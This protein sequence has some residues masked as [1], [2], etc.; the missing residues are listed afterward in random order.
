MKRFNKIVITLLIL[1]LFTSCVRIET[2]LSV[3]KDGSGTVTEKVMFSKVFVEMMS[4]LGESFGGDSDVSESFSIYDEEKLIGKA[5]DYG[6]GVKYQSSKKISENDWEGYAATYAFT[7]IS[8]VKLNTD[9]NDKIDTGMEEDEMEGESMMDE[10]D[11]YYF[12]SFE[13]GGNPKLII[14]RYEVDL[15]EESEE[16]MFEDAY[17]EDAYNEDDYNEDADMGSGMD[18]MGNE[19]MKMFEDMR[20]TMTIIVDGDISN[21][22]ASYTDG[23]K[24]TLIDMDF[25]EMMKNKDAFNQLS[26]NEPSSVEE[27]KAVMDMFEGLKMEFEPQV[28]VSFK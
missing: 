15:N 23:S 16:E 7:D 24:I 28:E 9:Q 18:A 6:E 20:F 25:G 8:K 26:E 10:K 1:T 14:N 12:F 21:T 5:T 3:N 19:M 17:N 11:E 27:M 22:N 2:I 4:S 13:K